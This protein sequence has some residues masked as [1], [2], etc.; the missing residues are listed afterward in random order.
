MKNSWPKTGQNSRSTDVR[1]LLLVRHG[2]P[3][4]RSGK[5]WDE[6]PGPML[7]GV[8]VVQIRQSAEVVA[9]YSP[10]R[11]WSSPLARA[12][13]SAALLAAK[14]D[15]PLVIDADLKEW[16]RT[17]SLYGV[18]QR[19]TRWLARWLARGERCAVV[20]GHASPILAV[21]RSA[22]YL[23]QR[24]WYAPGFS[25]RLEVSMGSVFELLI[26]PHEVSVRCLFHPTPRIMQLRGT[27]IMR[28]Y[29]RPVNPG[30]NGFLR[31][32]NQLHL[33]GAPRR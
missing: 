4:Y 25:D 8:G 32:P 12:T 7:S 9:R 2:L 29:P 22:L 19:N 14:S 33:I 1:R 13:Q 11:I 6:P 28:T 20:V 15:A 21:I 24:Y 18:T 17:D 16:H 30:E 5:A 10:S 23:P 3:D 31:R 26:H 27:T